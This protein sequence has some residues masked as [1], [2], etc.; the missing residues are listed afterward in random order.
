MCGIY[1]K[2]SKS[3]IALHD[4]ITAADRLRHRGPDGAG[5]MSVQRQPGSASPPA[6]YQLFERTVA[7]LPYELALLHRRLAIVD[8]MGGIQ[9]MCN[10]DRKVWVTFNG[11]IYNFQGIRQELATLGH[12][13]VTDHSDTEVIVH[14]WEQWGTDC[15]SRFNGMFAFAI[16]DA[17]RH[18]LFLARDRA[19]EKPLYYRHSAELFEFASEIQTLGGA[20][21]LNA[22][23]L[24]FYLS[25][26][27][28]P[29]EQSLFAGIVKLPP[30]HAALLDLQ[31][32]SLK[33]WPYWSLPLPDE[34]QRS[35]GELVEELEALLID[36]VAIRLVSDVPLGVFLSGGLDSSLVAAAAARAHGKGLRTFT[37]TFPGA[38]HYDEAAHARLVAGALGT[39]HVELAAEQDALGD[40]A[41][42]L[43]RMGEPLGDSSLLPTW[44]VSKLSRQ[45]VTVALGGDGGDELFAGYGQYGATARIIHRLGWVPQ[46]IWRVGAACA[47]MLPPG[48]RGRNWLQSMRGSPAQMAVWG[49]PFFDVKLRRMMLGD[50]LGHQLA[51]MWEEPEQWRL[52]LMQG[53]REVIGQLTRMD[54]LS[55][56]PEDILVKVDRASMMNSLEV[57]APWL[58]HR[59]VEFAFSRVPA[60]MKFRNGTGKW[61]TK[62]LV[63]RLL[64][65][66]FDTERKQGFSIPLDGWLR[67]MSCTELERHLRVP[68]PP[69]R[70]DSVTNLI[71]GEAKGRNNGARLSSLMS[72]GYCVGSSMS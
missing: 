22:R 45:H 69:F 49:T 3:P 12:Q 70:S 58:D 16:Y 46:P 48:Y 1:G 44:M 5:L 25:L 40:L 65:N 17:H 39:D 10:E 15:L 42:V 27:Y 18:Q 52:S 60:N 36:A 55:Y 28:S 59:L 32:F 47:A 31:T 62:Q 66:S 35:A 56:L 67:R 63:A 51:G 4:V 9:P 20:R 21:E 71:A 14:A 29:A 11:E 23:A 61:L 53:P 33:T 68:Q 64:P 43:G 26:G 41:S 38:G 24:N 7:E 34:S 50:H 6:D 2:V 54:F 37:I 72:L 57:R 13:F 30:A 19:G 8:P